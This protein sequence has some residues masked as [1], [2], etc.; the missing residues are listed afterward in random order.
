[1]EQAALR[2]STSEEVI[3]TLLLQF[4]EGSFDEIVNRMVP[5]VRLTRLEPG[6]IDFQFFRVKDAE[7]KF[8]V[9][10]RWRD[11]A[12]LDL[13][14]TQPYTQDVLKLFEEKLARPLSQKDDVRYLV[15]L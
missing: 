2:E 12:A 14:W 9:F 7:D 15:A 8:F 13:H 4:K 3:V 5:A 6:N 1:M 10:E 11:Q